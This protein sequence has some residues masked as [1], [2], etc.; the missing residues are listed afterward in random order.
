MDKITIDEINNIIDIIKSSCYQN[1][2]TYHNKV[3][4]YLVYEFASDY[5]IEVITEVALQFY[6]ASDE[7][8]L[9]IRTCLNNDSK[10]TSLMVLYLISIVKYK[11]DQKYKK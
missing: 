11:L 4:N 9:K 10:K 8:I 6:N 5:S 3:I 1:F 7:N 2:L